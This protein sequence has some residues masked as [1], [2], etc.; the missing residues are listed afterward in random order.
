M[1]SCSRGTLNNLASVGDIG[2]LKSILSNDPNVS[3]AIIEDLLVTATKSS[4]V[5]VIN[6]LLSQYPS[7]PLSEQIVRGAVNTGSIPI[8]KA[9]LARDPSII[10]MPF[11]H[12][13]SPLIVACMGRQKIEYLEYLLGVGADPNQ[14]PD[15]ASFPL[16]IVAALYE[17]PEVIDLLLNHGARVV[18]SGALGAAARL[19]NEVMMRRLL[20]RG[21][22]PDT[23]AATSES[24]LHTAVR[25]GHVGIATILLQDGADPMS[26]DG[27][28]CTPIDIAEK[29]RL[30]GNDMSE[31]LQVLRRK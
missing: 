13:G 22:K 15:A 21:A 24:P 26:M 12:Y 31:M 18:H 3:L 28:G 20:E 23:D 11:D 30:E 10:N 7:T 29:K 2:E 8:M 17:E 27:N 5:E 14:D 1:T 19:G 9:L 6:L 4:Q 16:T 25:A